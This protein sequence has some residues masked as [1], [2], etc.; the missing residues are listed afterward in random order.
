MAQRMLE[1]RVAQPPVHWSR[2]ASSLSTMAANP[3]SGP[4]NR[5]GTP[6]WWIVCASLHRIEF[7]VVSVE[8]YLAHESVG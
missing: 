5:S 7:T 6:T 4:R 8:V 1:G 3:A 2:R